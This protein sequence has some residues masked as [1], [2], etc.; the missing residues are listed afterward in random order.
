[1]QR[2][3]VVALKALAAL[4][5]THVAIISGPALRDLSQHVA[6][7][8]EAHLVGSHGSEFEAGFATPLAPG[9]LEL[10]QRVVG[11]VQRVA[12]KTPGALVEQKPASVTFHYRLADPT[13]ASAAVQEL[14]AA[15]ADWPGLQIRDGK[16][17]VELSVVPTN[18]GRALESLRQPRRHRRHLPGR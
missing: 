1:M 5:Q 7:A 18:K 10:L 9:V 4:P 3:S 8:Q 14:L 6:E 12:A 13:Q 2:E 16:M 17:V 15:V 11:Q